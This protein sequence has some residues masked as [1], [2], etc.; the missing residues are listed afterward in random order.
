MTNVNLTNYQKMDVT[1]IF[2]TAHSETEQSLEKQLVAKTC[3][4]PP[5]LSALLAQDD[6]ET[7]E[8]FRQQDYHI[9]ARHCV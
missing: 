3:L 4:H 5:H 7:V 8:Y 9:D 6:E 1:N 2:T